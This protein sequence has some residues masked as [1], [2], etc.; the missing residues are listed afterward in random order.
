M[1]TIILLCALCATVPN[2]RA[3][4]QQSAMSVCEVIA[5]R[6][7][8]SGRM[9]TVRGVEVVVEGGALYADRD[10]T[11]KLVTRGVVWP[12][13]INLAY[14][15]NSQSMDPNTHA[16]FEADWASIERS[17][18]AAL[19]AGYKLEDDLK[20]A[21][22]VGLLLTYDNDELGRRSNA[23]LRVPFLLGFGQAGFGAP[24]QLVIRSERDVVI[25]HGAAKGFWKA[26]DPG[27][28]VGHPGR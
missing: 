6:M 17:E 11:Y 9:V 28:G 18:A 19:R 20:V 2:A 26:W 24:A 7:E 5:R 21:T 27:A 8:F 14:P 25:L 22:Y 23:G 3:A 16:P 10:C 13:V 12:N 15:N 1:K 4:D